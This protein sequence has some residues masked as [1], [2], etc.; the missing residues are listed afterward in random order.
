MTEA[1]S[2]K[3]K[4]L[5]VIEAARAVFLE[6]GYSAARVN[7]IAARAGVS[8]RT[9][10]KY[11][12]SKT[13]LFGEVIVHASDR[14]HQ[15]LDMASEVGKDPQATL[16][17]VGLSYLELV[18]APQ[19]LDLNRTVIAEAKRFP[20]LGATFHATGYQRFA[21]ELASYLADQD[22]RGALCVADPD[23][24]ADQFLG[25]CLGS[26]RLRA[27]FDPDVMRDRPSME[28][29]VETAVSVFLRGC[30]YVASGERRNRSDRDALA[31]V[32]QA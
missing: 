31:K 17:L 10:Y 24:L 18:L 22:A 28:R 8:K 21:R 26:L 25:F 4:R 11:F 19:A 9:L 3:R 7:E 12:P 20:E 14:L 23:I 6:E 30:G 1:E 32:R 15:T 13:K 16:T 29:W 2:T 5:D 27:Y